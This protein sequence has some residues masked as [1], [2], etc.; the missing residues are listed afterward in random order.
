MVN[1]CLQIN[2]VCQDLS[3]LGFLFSRRLWLRPLGNGGAGGATAPP[4]DIF[5]NPKKAWNYGENA[6]ICR[7]EN[8]CSTLFFLFLF[9]VACQRGRWCT[10]TL[11]LENWPKE[12]VGRKNKCVGVP[13]PPFPRSSFISFFRTCST[14][15]AGDEPIKK[16]CVPSLLSTLN[17]QSTN[18]SQ[19]PG[20]CVLFAS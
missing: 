8:G 10:P 19:G 4:L 7:C 18:R 9:F 12:I 3:F 6:V 17:P 2:G 14:F 1:G 15:K 5:R 11:Y 20:L 13:P 16:S